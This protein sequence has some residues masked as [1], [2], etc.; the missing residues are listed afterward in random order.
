VIVW[1]AERQL[2]VVTTGARADRLNMV[3]KPKITPRGRLVA[4]LASRR[5]HRMRLR[6]AGS[7]HRIVAADTLRR[8][9]LEAS[10]HMA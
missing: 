4:A 5:R 2:A 10:V 8:H 3:D 7:G 9:A 6:L 1:L